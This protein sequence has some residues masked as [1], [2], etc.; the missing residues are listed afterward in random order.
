MARLWSASL[1]GR[2]A[3]SA[4]LWLSAAWAASL[5][6]RLLAWVGL[7]WGKAVSGSLFLSPASARPRRLGAGAASLTERAAGLSY[8][9][10]VRFLGHGLPGRWARRA[11]VATGVS[12][13]GDGRWLAVIGGGLTAFS[14]TRLVAGQWVGPTDPAVRSGGAPAVALVGF[15]ALG[16]AGVVMV[17][18][19]PRLITG[20]R[21]SLAGRLAGFVAGALPGADYGTVTETALPSS[22]RQGPGTG[23]VRV[24]ACVLA[25]AVGAFAGATPGLSAVVAP[26]LGMGVVFAFFV[27]YRPEV[28]PALLAAFPWLDWAARRALGGTGLAAAWDEMFLLGSV[29][30]LAFGVF[31]L[32]RWDLWTVPVALPVGAALVAATGSVAVRQV[33]GEVAV[34]ALRITFQP[35]LFFFLGYLLPRDRRSVRLALGVFLAAGL[36]LALHG[37]YQYATHAPMPA[38]WVD[39]R[40]T[41]IG[42]RAYSIIENPNGLGAF[43]ALAATLAAGLAVHR[44]PGRQRLVAAGVTLVLLAGLAVTFSR[45]AWLGF[46][47]GFAAMAALDQRRLLAGMVGAAVLSPLLVPAAFLHRLTFAFSSE[48]LAKSAAAGRLFMWRAALARIGEHPWLGLGL[49]TFGGTSSFLFGYSKLWVDNFY[50][51]MAAEGGLVLLAAFLWLLLRTA[52]CLVAAHQAQGEDPFLRAAT[53]GV[54]GGFVAVGFANLTAAVWETLAVGAGF[55]FLTGLAA[56]LARPFESLPRAREAALADDGA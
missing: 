1:S 17:A 52:K 13:L 43:L 31:V 36:L 22:V 56:S 18:A 37:L 27:L 23:A 54:F 45:G 35:L 8:A 40:E 25:A 12:A 19:G 41:N 14:V 4:G 9:R 11:G 32:C 44:L 2:L 29:A 5:T 30:T 38:K 15:A 53:A 10:T 3:A 39:V 34:F 47:V 51:Q 24:T 7:V 55:W 28:L 33:P 21:V 50:V 48:Y 42:T 16:V 26:V 20:W 6:G 49:G 46:I